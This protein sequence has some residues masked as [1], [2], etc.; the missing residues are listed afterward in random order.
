M[1]IGRK[2]SIACAALV[3]LTMLLGLVAIV[4]IGRIN[5]AVHSIATGS[6][7]AVASIA[8]LDSLIK[9]Q[10]SAMLTHILSENPEHMS[11]AESAITDL[12][13]KVQTEIR[14]YESTITN[15]RDRELFGRIGPAQEQLALEWAGIQPLSKA[16]KTKEALALWLAKGLPAAVAAGA[17][18]DEEIEFNMANGG[19]SAA[20]VLSTGGSARFW[21]ILILICTAVC[22]G[23]FAFHI[24]V[25]INRTLLQVAT[26]LGAGAGRVSGASR[27]VSTSGQSLAQGATEQAAALE[28]TSASSEELASM[29]RKNAEN[30][31]QATEF[32][33]AMS[34]RVSEANRTLGEMM[35]SMREIGASSGKISKIIK[36][37]DEIA[38]QTNILALN[39]AFEAARAG[40]A[41]MGFAVVAGEV[42]SLAQRSAK[43]AKDTAG[44][45]EDSIAK[46]GEGGRKL[47]EVAASIQAITE[48][49]A[50]VKTLVDE[51]DASSKEQAMG[52]EQISQSIA[53]MDQVTQRT[54][55]NAEQS[56]GA[57]DALH[58]ESQKLLAVVERLQSIVG[59]SQYRAER[60]VRSLERRSSRP[61]RNSRAEAASASHKPGPSV[62]LARNAGE[63][64]LD[65][66]EFKDF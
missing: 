31:Q 63:F 1:T 62:T 49:A 51:V 28:E 48:G 25:G 47:S 37:I 22:G 8:R 18:C 26:E 20:A 33:H 45:I 27:Q 16:L 3:A 32:M 4:K 35:T 64:P 7:P 29:T 66:S 40:E 55:T 58:A 23:A 17:A 46:S 5:A 44:L 38:F 15:S 12:Q 6:L 52:I 43:A 65:D 13:N 50:R 30:S 9:E 56:A 42:R 14:T 60:G 59:A 10:R 53:Q 54:A 36:V 34:Q 11:Q 2:I 57:G 19:A 61:G 21:M 24:V 39:A 41:G